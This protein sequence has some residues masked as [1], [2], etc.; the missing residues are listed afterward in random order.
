MCDSLRSKAV[1]SSMKPVP[2]PQPEGIAPS[3]ILPEHHSFACL[4]C[5]APAALEW[6]KLQTCVSPSLD[7][8]PLE[9]SDH[10]RD[11]RGWR[12]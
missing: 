8:E 1:T 9:G 3:S 6:S 5:L 12:G 11:L 4:H 2:W 10:R 7:C